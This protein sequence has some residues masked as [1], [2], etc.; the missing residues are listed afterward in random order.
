MCKPF[1]HILKEEN[2]FLTYNEMVR[3]IL[4]VQFHFADIEKR[5]SCSLIRNTDLIIPQTILLQCKKYKKQVKF[6]RCKKHKIKYDSSV[7]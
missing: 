5:N 6:R 7:S 4:S 3:I 1:K 2:H